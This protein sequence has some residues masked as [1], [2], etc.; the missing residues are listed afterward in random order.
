MSTVAFAPA[1]PRFN[2]RQLEPASEIPE[3]AAAP[4]AC[5][6]P[7]GDPQN[8]PSPGSSQAKWRKKSAGRRREASL[9]VKELNQLLPRKVPR[10][11]DLKI[12]EYVVFQ[13]MS[14]YDVAELF[15]ISQPR[16]C[17]IVEEVRTWKSTVP[18][19]IPGMTDEQ[20]VNLATH[21][22]RRWLEVIR[23]K[24]MKHLDASEKDL[25]FQKIVTEKQEEVQRVDNIK[26]Q[27]PKSGFLNIA[28]KAVIKSGELGGAGQQWAKGSAKRAQEPGARGQKPGDAGEGKSQTRNPQPEFLNPK[29][30]T[31]NPF[32]HL[33]TEEQ[34]AFSPQNGKANGHKSSV[35]RGGAQIEKSRRGKKREKAYQ[36]AANR[37]GIQRRPAR[38]R[39]KQLLRWLDRL[40]ERAEIAV[41]KELRSN[42]NRGREPWSDWHVQQLRTRRLNGLLD[43]NREVDLYPPYT[44]Q[45][46]SQQYDSAS[47]RF[48]WQLEESPPP[49]GK[50]KN[51]RAALPPGEGPPKG[52]AQKND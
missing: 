7:A 45:W 5:E 52:A 6:Q 15:G 21:E 32:P 41:Q 43:L 39:F 9:R 13:Q 16:V 30:R 29:P 34:P 44:R 19:Q 37:A 46:V 10:Q 49:E 17:Q 48:R 27:S 8:P 50:P 24:A 31:L 23:D 40:A 42:V 11:R 18:G 36:A 51:P 28:L 38:H 14:Q 35:V 3:A 25:H 47:G 1:A 4:I 20:Q 22:T 2:D 26:P 33:S 12:Y